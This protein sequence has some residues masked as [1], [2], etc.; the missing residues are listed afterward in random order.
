VVSM[1]SSKVAQ[2]KCNVL[3]LKVPQDQQDTSFHGSNSIFF[4]RARFLGSLAP[5]DDILD[6]H[7]DHVL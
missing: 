4:C 2:V 7:R 1:A 6:I 5:N 3:V